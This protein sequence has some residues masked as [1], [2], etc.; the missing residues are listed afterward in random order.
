[1][2][3][4]LTLGLGDVRNISAVPNGSD[5]QEDRVGTAAAEELSELLVT[6][7]GAGLTDREISAYLRL[8]HPE[9]LSGRFL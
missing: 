3:R 5:G 9:L 2:N 4:N 1:M 8:V 6:L 7:R